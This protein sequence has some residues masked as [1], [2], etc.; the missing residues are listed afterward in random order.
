MAA[1]VE[2][3][4]ISIYYQNAI[5]MASSKS[6]AR[7]RT[8]WCAS[9]DLYVLDE[10]MGSRAAMRACCGAGVKH[11][12]T[13]RAMTYDFWYHMTRPRRTALAD[14]MRDGSGGAA[15]FAISMISRKACAIFVATSSGE[16]PMNVFVCAVVRTAIGRTFRGDHVELWLG[17]NGVRAEVRRPSAT[18][19]R[20]V[21]GGRSSR[22]AWRGRRGETARSCRTH[23][24]AT[25]A[26]WRAVQES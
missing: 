2:I 25:K 15:Q 5:R 17:D 10:R 23:G 24:R 6:I 26:M 1:L 13:A 12:L 21:I 22:V 9:D 16:P 3:E 11:M 20:S 4:S 18:V 7:E 19:E 8:G 14:R